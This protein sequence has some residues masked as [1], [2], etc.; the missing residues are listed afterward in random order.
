MQLQPSV[1]VVEMTPLP[2]CRIDT[3]NGGAGNDTITTG[4]GNDTV[5][6]GAGDDTLVFAANLATGDTIPVVT[7][8]TPFLLPMHH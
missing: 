8:L 3:L 5:N 2:W 4:A 1:V 6:G 7:A